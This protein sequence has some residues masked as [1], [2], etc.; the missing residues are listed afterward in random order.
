[1]SQI[2]KWSSNDS[3]GKLSPS[4][5]RTSSHRGPGQA[6]AYVPRT[7]SPFA[8]VTVTPSSSCSRPVTW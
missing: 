5:P 3:P 8:Q 2:R 6:T 4:M 1:M 7:V